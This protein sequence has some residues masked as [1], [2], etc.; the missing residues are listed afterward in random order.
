MTNYG[1][2]PAVLASSDAPLR[3]LA[4]SLDNMVAHRRLD[5]TNGVLRKTSTIITH[6]DAWS[7]CSSSFSAY[8]S[9]SK[10]Y[11]LPYTTSTIYT[12]VYDTRAY[13]FERPMTTLCDGRARGNGPYTT[14]SVETTETLDPPWTTVLSSYYTEEYPSC[15]E[16]RS[17]RE[18][19]ATDA[20]A[21]DAATPDAAVQIFDP[22]SFLSPR[23]A[24]VACPGPCSIAAYPNPTLLY[25]A[26]KT[27]SGDFCAQNGTTV[28]QEPTNFPEPNKAVVDGITIT[29][30][31]NYVSFSGV[32]GYHR[33]DCG[34]KNPCGP[35]RDNVLL[36]ITGP[37]YSNGFQD[38]EDYSFN[39]ADLNT[40]PE[41]AW[42]KQRQCGRDHTGCR[43]EPII[44]TEYTP[45]LPLP[46]EVLDIEPEV[47]K[48]KCTGGG[49]YF[50]YSALATPAPT[51]VARMIMD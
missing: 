51:M 40:V 19:T 27:V 50:H 17:T 46:T 18:A 48:A 6:D 47:W 12:R 31:T 13:S 8:W 24:Q 36:P 25:W 41:D 49:F 44:Q 32:Q 23:G 9:S 45:I 20:T 42:T 2:I 3:I 15:T 7:S 22:D 1:R 33:D 14:Y 11:E 21:T 43:N 26:V 5:T 35:S 38:Y 10:E 16:L 4:R 37:F 39:V 29:S 28:A 34:R 30:P